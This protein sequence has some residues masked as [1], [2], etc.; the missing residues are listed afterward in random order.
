MGQGTP[1]LWLFFLFKLLSTLHNYRNL[2]YEGSSS[3]EAV[4]CIEVKVEIHTVE[5]HVSLGYGNIN[6]MLNEAL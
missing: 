4:K 5:G 3:T 2:V 6:N 1:M